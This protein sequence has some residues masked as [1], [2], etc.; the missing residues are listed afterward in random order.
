[1]IKPYSFIIIQKLHMN[2][3]SRTKDFYNN[4]YVINHVTSLSYHT[5]YHWWRKSHATSTLKIKHADTFFTYMGTDVVPGLAILYRVTPGTC[6]HPFS[7]HLLK[8]GDIRDLR[9]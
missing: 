4:P 2:S 5:Y 7:A 8:S 9:N 3:T 6:K 1:M